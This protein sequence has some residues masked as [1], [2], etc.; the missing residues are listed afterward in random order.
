MNKLRKKIRSFLWWIW[1]ECG[2]GK[3]LALLAVVIAVVYSP[4]WGGLLLHRLFRWKWALVVATGYAL[5]WAGP[6]TPFFP[7]CVAITL[8]IKK[9]IRLWKGKRQEKQQKTG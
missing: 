8:T 6:A 3:T 1:R 9:G 7:L 2:N 5:F 4:V